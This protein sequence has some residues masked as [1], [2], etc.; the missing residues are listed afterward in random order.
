MRTWLYDGSF[1]GF[2]TAL[3]LALER[4]EDCA[5][6]RQD[7]AEA[8]LFSEFLSAGRDP[9]RAAAV[10]KVI[11]T[12][13][14]AESWQHARY[15]F[16]S[17]SPGAETAI[18]K[19]VSLLLEKGRAAYNML[20]D[21]R[22]RAVHGLAAKVG[23][24]A[25][26]FMGFVRF[27]ELADKTLYS[28]IEPDHNILPLL[29]GHFRARLGAFN[30]VIHDA[31]RNLAALYF[32]GRLVYAPLDAAS[33]REDA[34]ESEVRKLWK[35]FFKTAAIKERLNPE[36]QRQNVPLKYRKNLTEFTE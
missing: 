28:R 36:L 16:L 11:E 15:A 23:G 4:P 1:E 33:L 19:Y 35:H 8:G 9:A 30:W 24:E 26:R 13:G 22:V 12:R 3:S 27:S 17:E 10:R 7:G 2:L 32:K 29:T 6:A 21:D 5:I 14:S 31:R 34:K 20:A 18:L 25:H